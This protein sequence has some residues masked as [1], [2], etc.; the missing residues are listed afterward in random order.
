LAKPNISFGFA[1]FGTKS[2][3]SILRP[4][5]PVII[6]HN[7]KEFKTYLLLDSGADISII[8]KDILEFL[9][10]DWKTI[11]K[12]G[13]T[14]CADGETS[15]VGLI[16]LEIVISERNTTWSEDIPF[17]CFLTEGKDPDP[18]LLGRHPFFNRY[19]IDFRMGYTDDPALGK[20]IIYKEEA[21]RDSKRFRA[22]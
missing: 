5:I 20:F 1:K 11:Q 8:R 9:E 3:Q 16:N 12:T 15:E 18:P 19:R 2:G 10:I 22:R 4:M 21:K 17:Q 6:K 14:Q 13:K 7:D